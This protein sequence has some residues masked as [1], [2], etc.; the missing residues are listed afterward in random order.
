[1]QIDR[2]D[3]ARFQRKKVRHSRS[4]AAARRFD[5]GHFECV[6]QIA[7]RQLQSLDSVAIDQHDFFINNARDVRPA[8]AFVFPEKSSIHQVQ[9]ED[10]IRISRGHQDTTVRDDDRAFHRTIDSV[11]LVAR[12]LRR[13][14]TKPGEVSRFRHDACR[15]LEPPQQFT[16]FFID[17]H[18]GPGRCR[19]DDH[20]IRNRRRQPRQSTRHVARQSALGRNQCLRPLL[21]DGLFFAVVLQDKQ[22]QDTLSF[23]QQVQSIIRR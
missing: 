22:L 6:F 10:M 4:Y 2:R 9:A 13:H 23:R 5:R 21:F 15:V 19:A 11:R 12:W 17:S 3:L 7:I 18:D 8:F 1:M 16:P 20:S 14:A